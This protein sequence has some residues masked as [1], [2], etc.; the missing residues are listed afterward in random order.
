MYNLSEPQAALSQVTLIF[1]HSSIVPDVPAW[2]VGRRGTT[3]PG[4]YKEISS[5]PLSKS[6]N[7]FCSRSATCTCGVQLQATALLNNVRARSGKRVEKPFKSIPDGGK[8]FFCST[9]PRHP[10]EPTGT[11][12]QC[13]TEPLSPVGPEQNLHR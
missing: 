12:K 7:G 9:A 8:I 6:F 13:V 1:L 10:L 4:K 2:P 5:P 3:T 11:I